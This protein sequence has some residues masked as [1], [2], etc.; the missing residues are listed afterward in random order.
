LTPR[1]ID[2]RLTHMQ[3]AKR[4]GVAPPKNALSPRSR[5]AKLGHQV[6]LTLQVDLL[7]MI[8]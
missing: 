3:L 8:D 5:T 7:F 1:P 4:C 2:L 6:Q